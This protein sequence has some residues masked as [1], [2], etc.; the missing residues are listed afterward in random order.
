MVPAC[1]GHVAFKIK[2]ELGGKKRGQIIKSMN[3]KSERW[4]PRKMAEVFQLA[5]EKDFSQYDFFVF[6]CTYSSQY[7]LIFSS[8]QYVALYCKL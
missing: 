7:N 4:S 1:D 8:E 6:Q 2:W 5:V 3:F